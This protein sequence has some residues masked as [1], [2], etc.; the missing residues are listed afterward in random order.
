[1]FSILFL[2]FFAV[3]SFSFQFLQYEPGKQEYANKDGVQWRT[4]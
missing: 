1:M 2:T 4:H 3:S